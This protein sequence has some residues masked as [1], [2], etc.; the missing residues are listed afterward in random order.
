M[1]IAIDDAGESLKDPEFSATMQRAD[2]LIIVT[3]APRE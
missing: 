3:P 2:G 1:A